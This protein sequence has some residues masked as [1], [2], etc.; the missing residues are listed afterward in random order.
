[1]IS[2]AWER[3]ATTDLEISEATKNDFFNGKPSYRRLVGFTKL[4]RLIGDRD[5]QPAPSREIGNRRWF[6]IKSP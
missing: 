6:V 2:P 1:M 3:C 5:D 4:V